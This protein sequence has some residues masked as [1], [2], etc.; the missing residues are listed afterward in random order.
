MKKM[1]KKCSTDQSFIRKRNTTFKIGTLITLLK[2][3]I[4]LRNRLFELII[5]ADTYE[6][7]MQKPE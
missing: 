6:L 4:K 3:K 1:L 2:P 5:N 7:I